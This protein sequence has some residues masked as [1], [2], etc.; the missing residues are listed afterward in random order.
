MLSW[1]VDKLIPRGFGRMLITGDAKVGK[2]LLAQRL[3]VSLSNGDPWLGAD[4][5][6]S[7][8]LY[9]VTNES[10]QV[11]AERFGHMDSEA[12]GID[13]LFCQGFDID[14]DNIAS[15]FKKHYD[16]LIIDSVNWAMEKCAQRCLEADVM[17][18]E[19]KMGLVIVA[20]S[21]KQT[22]ST[23]LGS[24]VLESWVDSIVLVSTT[25]MR[26]G[27]ENVRAADIVSR[28]APDERQLFTISEII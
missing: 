16:V 15:K 6:K 28:F 4:T 23:R 5:E 8:V 12:T 14:I 24:S 11:V 7:S 22:S 1:Y 26:K 9:A 17:L 21:R 10:K 2:S 13:I 25:G 3:A 20:N 18:N 19:R 27:K